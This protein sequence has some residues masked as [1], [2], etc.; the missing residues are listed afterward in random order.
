MI[1][2]DGRPSAVV[3]G[4]QNGAC[5]SFVNPISLE[6]LKKMVKD[7]NLCCHIAQGISENTLNNNDKHNDEQRSDGNHED[8]ARDL[9]TLLNDST[10]LLKKPRV[11]W[12]PDLETK[13]FNAVEHLG[14][15]GMMS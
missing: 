9:H 7:G 12:T 13:F 5:A 2:N 6:E 8:I 15:E 3:R 1:S 4:L 10:P 14:L 11:S